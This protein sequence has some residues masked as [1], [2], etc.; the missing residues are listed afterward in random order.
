MGKTK[1][2]FETKKKN[3]KSFQIN[4]FRWKCPLNV[5]GETAGRQLARINGCY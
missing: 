3:P 1:D 4:V 2:R 5:P